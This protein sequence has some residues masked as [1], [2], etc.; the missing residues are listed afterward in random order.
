[1]FFLNK[2]FYLVS[3]VI[4][5]TAAFLVWYCVAVQTKKIITTS[6]DIQKENL[7]S[8]AQEEKSKKIRQMRSEWS[9]I[10]DSR[11]KM[12]LTLIGRDDMVSLIESLE[13]TAV[14]TGNQIEIDVYDLK[15]LKAK[16]KRTV[17][18]N[19]NAKKNNEAKKEDKNNQDIKDKLGFSL[20]LKGTFRSL[21]DFLN[22][23]E[24]FPYFIKVHSLDIN[25]LS[26]L[27]R[28]SRKTDDA[29]GENGEAEL[30][31][32]IKSTIIIVVYTDDK[33]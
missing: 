18:G 28:I 4:V 17:S 12:E 15:K 6:E 31:K 29:G 3:A 2:K 32:K 9:D 5:L 25:L 19:K 26:E 27:Q 33:D 14:D 30:A 13:N 20:E 10:E 16:N 21:I 22:K 24:N 8:L 1:M 7:N 23:V 11:K